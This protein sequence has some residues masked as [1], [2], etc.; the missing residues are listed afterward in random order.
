MT[1]LRL[2][3]AWELLAARAEA[4]R[5]CDSAE[6]LG[7]WQNACLLARAVTRW[8]RRRFASGA[9]VMQRW[10]PEQIEAQTL[11]YQALARRHDPHCGQPPEQTEAMMQRLRQMP[12]S[13]IQWRVLRAFGVLPSEPRAR[14]MT[15]GDYLYCVLHLLL[16]E[17]ERLAR[18]CPD[19]RRQV[20]E[21]HCPVCGK[22]WE[23]GSSFDPARFDVLKGGGPG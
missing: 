11:R 6:S 2:L 12:E 4:E 8:G 17:D 18:L 13:R 20:E 10:T 15:R 5:A 7:L 21:D 9:A 22:Q 19:C 1:G 3:T 16:D 14:R 23:A